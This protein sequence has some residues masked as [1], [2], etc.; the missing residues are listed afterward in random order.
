MP[1]NTFDPQT[2]FR[3]AEM[4]QHTSVVTLPGVRVF[5]VAGGAVVLVNGYSSNSNGRCGDATR[6]LSL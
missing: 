5:V 3:D 1:D 6:V 2:F 4:P